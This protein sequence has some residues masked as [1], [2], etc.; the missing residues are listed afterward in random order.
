MLN[1]FRAPE[2]RDRYL[3]PLV[4]GEIIQSFGMT[5]PGGRVVR[6]HAAADHGGARRRR[7]GDQ[8]AEVVHQPGALCEVHDGHRPHQDHAER[9]HLASSAIIVPTDTPGYSI[10][11][12][13]PVF[14]ELEGDHCEVEYD[15]VRVPAGNSRARGV[16]FRSART[17][18]P[19]RIFHAMRFLGR[20]ERAYDLMCDRAVRAD[21]G[22]TARRQAVDP[23]DGVR[24][25]GR[26][27]GLPAHRARRGRAYG[28][29]RP[30]PGRDRH[31]QGADRGGCST[32]RSTGPS[33]CTAAWG[34]PATSHSSASTRRR[35]SAASGTDPT[36]PTSS[37]CRA[38]C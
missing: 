10:V 23:A 13:V 14:G 25:G 38:C 18:G 2:W 27:P 9:L 4:E 34:S 31:D 17:L 28:P 29:G 36:R 21:R 24:D 20:A 8:R 7:V 30:G 32:T 6:R 12:A 3:G 35:A 22:G 16:G 1:E 19:G 37:P 5:E 11:R 26:D 33:R 15:N